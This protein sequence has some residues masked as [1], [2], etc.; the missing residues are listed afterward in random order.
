MKNTI[1]RCTYLVESFRD[2][3]YDSDINMIKNRGGRVLWFNA[4]KVYTLSNINRIRFSYNSKP[5]M[6]GLKEIGKLIKYRYIEEHA[7]LYNFSR[8]FNIMTFKEK[9]RRNYKDYDCE[10]TEEVYE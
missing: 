3:Y 10:D 2:I 1:R 7:T 6:Y 5:Y 8:N 4:N 9:I